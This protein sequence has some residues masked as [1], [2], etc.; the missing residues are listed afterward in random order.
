MT[1]RYEE[2]RKREKELECAEREREAVCSCLSRVSLL[3]LL[4][5]SLQAVC[6]REK[7]LPMNEKEERKK[8]KSFS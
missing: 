7:G 2:K 8:G 1:T 5:Q 3:F 4:L 6:A